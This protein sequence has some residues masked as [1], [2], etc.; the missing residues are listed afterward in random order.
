MHQ[1]T[2][3]I[4]QIHPIQRVYK[5]P[6]YRQVYVLG[7]CLSAFVVVGFLSVVR[8]RT[9]AELILFLSTAVV[10]AVQS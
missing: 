2:R 6:S 8:G 4:Q 9:D 1:N 7:F 10:V 3:N 5:P